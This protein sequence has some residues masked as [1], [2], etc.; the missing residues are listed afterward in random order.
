MGDLLTQLERHG[1]LSQL[2]SFHTPADRAILLAGEPPDGA[3]L[4]ESGQAVV[5][6][7]D[8]RGGSTILHRYLPGELFGELELICGQN[9]ATTVY[10]ATDCRGYRIPAADFLPLLA[11]ENWLCMYLLHKLAALQLEEV[12]RVDAR[13]SFTVRQKVAQLLLDSADAGGT[14]VLDK[15]ETA[16]ILRITLRSVHRALR[17]LQDEGLVCASAHR[18]QLLDEQALRR[19]LPPV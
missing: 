5:R 2:P 10:A 8:S 9:V 7:L 1:L 14:V 11:R 16:D 4:L 18:V 6:T 12:P 19:L 13:R 3:Y 17:Q 15:Q